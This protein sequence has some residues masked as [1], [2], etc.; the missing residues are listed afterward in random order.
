MDDFHDNNPEDLDSIEVDFSDFQEAF[1]VEDADDVIAPAAPS[2]GPITGETP[3]GMGKPVFSEADVFEVGGDSSADE[4]DEWELDGAES[5]VKPD[6]VADTNTP[7]QGF[8]AKLKQG[9]EES[10][11]KNSVPD[12]LA[13]IQPPSS[14]DFGGQEPPSDPPPVTWE[15][16]DEEEDGPNVPAWMAEFDNEDE[17]PVAK[18]GFWARL[19]QGRDEYAA[20]EENKEAHFDMAGVDV[21]EPSF[22]ERMTQKFE[23]LTKRGSTEAA[24]DIQ[25][26]AHEKA[27]RFAE[28]L[29]P[30]SETEIKI[31]QAEISKEE[32]LFVRIERSRI[33]G[34]SRQQIGFL[35]G[36]VSVFLFMM[37]L[38]TDYL[39]QV[40]PYA[41]V[42]TW[43]PAE[44]PLDAVSAGLFIIGL[45]VPVFCIIVVADTVHY[46]WRGIADKRLDDVLLAVLAGLCSF[47]SL[48]ALKYGDVVTAAALG[49]T[50]FVTRSIARWANG[51]AR[52]KADRDA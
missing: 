51:L 25:N 46:L 31:L 35:V 49:L 36:I 33:L 38:G 6:A 19:K 52:R 24:N 11:Q 5:T 41:A 10:K 26:E 2:F 40:L 18:T 1:S 50:W 15:D 48:V 9:R 39:T 3:G 37:S 32:P 17:A 21:E 20:D 28:L 23:L 30:I 42:P 14:N 45:L 44:V 4:E 34:N 29:T 16:P 7:K 8:L 13:D 43:I 27:S 12:D 22:V 47:T